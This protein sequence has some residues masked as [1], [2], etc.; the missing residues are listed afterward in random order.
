MRRRLV[1]S[2]LGLIVLVAAIVIAATMLIAP[3]DGTIDLGFSVGLFGWLGLC[4][5]L[6]ALIAFAPTGTPFAPSRVGLWL[7]E[8][9][10]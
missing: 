8:S 3:G 2:G 9:G 4:W 1:I 7:R 10:R 5:A 6:G